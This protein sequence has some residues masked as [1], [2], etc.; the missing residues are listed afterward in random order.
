MQVTSDAGDPR[1]YLTGETIDVAVEFDHPVF[2]DTANGTPYLRLQIGSETEQAGYST[3]D[4]T[5]GIL[6]FA[7]TVG[8]SANDQNGVSIPTN[9]I[10]LNGGVIRYL[11]DQTD[12]VLEHS[13]VSHQSDH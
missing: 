1:S 11:R 9:A 8:G 4:A 5:F 13:A 10:D 12:V 6:T 2:V 3:T 7:Y